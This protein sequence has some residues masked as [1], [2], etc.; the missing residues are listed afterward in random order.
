MSSAR[1]L[2]ATGA[3]VLCH[4]RA[5][6]SSEKRGEFEQDGEGLKAAA[7]QNAEELAQEALAKFGRIDILI[8]NDAYPAHRMPIDKADMSLVRETVERLLVQPYEFTAAVTPHMKAQTSGKIIFVTS[9]AP[10]GGL[11]NYSPYAAAR[12]GVNAMVKSL[13]LELASHNIQVNAIAPNFIE[14]PDYF[15]PELM[16]DPEKG[17]RVLKNVPL[18]RLGTQEEAASLVAYLASQ[19]ANFIT[20]QV[21]S[22]AGGWA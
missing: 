5:F 22:L 19:E 18:G 7:S 17:P 2:R 13:A 15:P 3:N 1:T 16:N 6:K 21:V 20:G 10:I 11:K 8:N 14:S 4:D 12:G 9:A